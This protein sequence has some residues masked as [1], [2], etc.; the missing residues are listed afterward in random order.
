MRFDL[1]P[2]GAV[3]DARA[4][5]VAEIDAAAA[6]ARGRFITTAAGQDATYRAK[7]DEAARFI[8][9]DYPADV[10]AY[11]W[12]AAESSRSGMAPRAAAD[13]I[14]Q[15]GDVWNQVLGP[16]IEG[17]RIAGKGS[18]AAAATVAVIVRAVRLVIDQL[19]QITEEGAPAAD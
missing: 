5:A 16:A 17:C 2:F 15:R 7:Y 19:A 12:I 9:A 10:S 4:W 18:V 13:R 14:K 1:H 3:D 8:A 11:P 6:S